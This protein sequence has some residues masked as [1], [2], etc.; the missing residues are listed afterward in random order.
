MCSIC[1]GF[2]QVHALFK[3]IFS[4]MN[5]MFWANTIMG[6]YCHLCLEHD[7]TI[8]FPACQAHLSPWQVGAVFILLIRT[9]RATQRRHSWNPIVQTALGVRIYAFCLNYSYFCGIM[10]LQASAWIFLSECAFWKI[11]T[12]W[13]LYCK[14]EVCKYILSISLV[15]ERQQIWKD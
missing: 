2:R 4:C 8:T 3:I 7:Y 10:Y 5:N 12:H 6:K 11:P 1:N 9:Q 13:R 15:P 14:R